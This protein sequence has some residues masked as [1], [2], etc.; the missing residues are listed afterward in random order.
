MF[1]AAAAVT[2]LSSQLSWKRN[3]KAGNSAINLPTAV[4]KVIAQG[5]QNWVDIQTC[6]KRMR[7]IENICIWNCCCMNSQTMEAEWVLT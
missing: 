3:A 2:L 4:K 1:A 6:Y 7:E 5:D